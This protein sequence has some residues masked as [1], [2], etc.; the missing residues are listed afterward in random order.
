M[1]KHYATF[2]FNTHIIDLRSIDNPYINKPNALNVPIIL[3]PITNQNAGN[4]SFL[5]N[6]VVYLFQQCITTI[7]ELKSQY[8]QHETQPQPQSTTILYGNTNNKKN[9]I[10]KDS[11]NRFLLI[12]GLL[13]RLGRN[14]NQHNQ[15][16][17]T[18]TDNTNND[19][20]DKI[21]SNRYLSPINNKKQNKETIEDPGT[22]IKED[23]HIYSYSKHVNYHK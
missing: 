7:H 11:R 13:E 15:I 21:I 16:Q 10:K 3:D 4:S 18:F 9:Q 23:N 17:L 2:D 19:H 22:P 20:R 5:I 12:D 8:E 6:D 1:L 14:G